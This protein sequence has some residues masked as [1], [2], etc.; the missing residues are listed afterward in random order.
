MEGTRTEK[1]VREW[2]MKMMIAKGLRQS[3]ET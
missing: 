3:G 1:E 2:K